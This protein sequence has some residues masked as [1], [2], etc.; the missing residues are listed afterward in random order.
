MNVDSRHPGRAISST[1]VGI[2]LGTTNSLCA[3]FRDGRPTLLANAHG[4]FLTPSVVGIMEDGRILVGSA[5]ADY[6]VTHPDRCAWAFKRLMGQP[7]TVTLGERGF[8]APELSS[9]VLRSLKT[10]AEAA[11]G[12]PITDAVI[13]VPAYFN[14]MQRKSTRHAAALAGIN[15]RRI[16][17]EPTA[18]ALTY[19]FHERDADKKLIIIDL[20]GGTFDVTLMHIFE[21]TLE[22]VSTAGESQLGGDDFTDRLVG[23]VCQ[24]L[25]KSLEAAELRQPL[26]VS[27]LRSECERAKRELLTAEQSIVRIPDDA[28]MIHDKAQRITV[29]REAFAKIVLDLVDRLRRPID[30]ALRDGRV[31]PAEV[32]DV[33]LVGGATRMHVVRDAVH[34]LF[35][36]KPVCGFN[37][38]EVVAL[39]AAIQ[40]ALIVDDAAVDD[41]VM[42]DV[43]PFTLG[44]ETVKSFGH[45][46]QDGYYAPVIHRNTTIPVSREEIFFTVQPHQTEIKLSIYQGESRRVQDNLKLGELHV[47]GL[48]PAPE[49]QPVRVRFTYD[50]DGILEVEAFIDATGERFATVLTNHAGHLSDA[51]IA[52][53]VTRMK[54]VKFYPRDDLENRKLVL[55]AERLIG[56]VPRDTRAALDAAVDSFESAMSSGDREVFESARNALLVML[57]SL[58]IDYDGHTGPSGS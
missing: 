45:H 22:I 37:P 28:G 58:G 16:I 42:T 35:G 13:T 9:L 25:G 4:D 27:R 12:Q 14:D 10:D 44:V 31:D 3:V 8:T 24:K 50:L 36:R 48:P 6:R 51:E 26:F 53:A 46:T 57:S 20:G 55:F 21:G 33:I 38:D 29:S 5:A 11:L 15:V 49:N 47:K 7:R 39:G 2:D 54:A 23:T 40:A 52:A 41:M 34:E 17:N 32:D 1:I 18:A 56:E 43:C 19:G 30:R